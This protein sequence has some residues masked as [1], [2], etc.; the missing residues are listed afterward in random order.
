[1]EHIPVVTL[2]RRGR[3]AFL[4][5]SAD[6]YKRLGIDV[7]HASRG[8]D[9]TYHAPGQLIMYPIIHLG[10]KEADA[11][12]YLYN[13][14]EIA[15]RTAAFFGVPAIRRPQKNGAWTEAGKIAAIGFRLRRWVTSH[16]MSFNVNLD[17]SGF[18]TIVP[19]GLVGETVAS[20]ASILGADAPSVR[21]VR[22][23]LGRHFGEIC[24]RPLSIETLDL[25]NHV[26]GDTLYKQVRDS[27]AAH[28]QPMSDGL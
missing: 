20:L 21:E 23:E 16:G 3:D 15:I 4:N 28:A 25:P 12:G 7:E 17:L 22:G 1:M 8:G 6:E 11:H 10:G 26:Q 27:L 19:C 24:D 2:G 18:D 13:L 5:L 9:V 14:E